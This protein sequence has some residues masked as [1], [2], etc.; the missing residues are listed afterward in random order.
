MA[1]TAHWWAGQ[2]RGWAPGCCP[3]LLARGRADGA[4]RGQ[5]WAVELPHDKPVLSRLR[6][7]P[8]LH[9][10]VATQPGRPGARRLQP[11][12]TSLPERG[13]EGSPAAVA[14]QEGEAQ[15]GLP[16]PCPAPCPVGAGAGQP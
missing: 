5:S 1:L 8:A 3:P 2:C 9:I 16:P 11:P 6:H 13:R 7:Q 4:C 12:G 14:Q 10:H 15:S